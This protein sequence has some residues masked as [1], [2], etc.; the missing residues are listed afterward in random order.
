ME[1]CEGIL[2]KVEVH[3]DDHPWLAYMEASFSK[4]L[5]QPYSLANHNHV[6]L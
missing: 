3:K 5:I 6:L 4:V 2:T 1:D